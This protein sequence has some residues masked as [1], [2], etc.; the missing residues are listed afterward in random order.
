MTRPQWFALP[1]AVRQHFW[2]D[3]DYGARAPSPAMVAA[4]EAAQ[5]KQQEAAR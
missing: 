2:K 3:T 1:L 4:I 5:Q